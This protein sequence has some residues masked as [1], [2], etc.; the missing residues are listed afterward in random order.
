[1]P[2]GKRDCKFCEGRDYENH[3]NVEAAKN[4]DTDPK[5]PGFKLWL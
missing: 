3:N 5:L 2:V 4:M 1:M